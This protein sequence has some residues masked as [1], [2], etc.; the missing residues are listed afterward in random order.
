MMENKKEI[1]TFEELCLAAIKAERDAH[2]SLATNQS[3]Q[4]II[5]ALHMEMKAIGELISAGNQTSLQATM[6]INDIAAHWKLREEIRKE[7]ATQWIIR[8]N[9]EPSGVP[10]S[11]TFEEEGS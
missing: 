11:N 2:E 10:Q 3:P 9:K 8:I 4:E 5:K 6:L 1:L 7:F